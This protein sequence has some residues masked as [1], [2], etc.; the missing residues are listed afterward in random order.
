[1]EGRNECKGENFFLFAP[2]VS[3]NGGEGAKKYFSGGRGVMRVSEAEKL[4]KCY[5]D[6]ICGTPFI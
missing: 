4:T 3:K 6:Y 5:V 2:G 1:M